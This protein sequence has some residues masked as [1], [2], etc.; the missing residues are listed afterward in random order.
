LINLS[1][2]EILEQLSHYRAKQKQGALIANPTLSRMNSRK[3]GKSSD[4]SAAF[5]NVIEVCDVKLD[6]NAYILLYCF[7]QC[8]VGKTELKAE[9]LIS[10]RSGTHCHGSQASSVGRFRYLFIFIAPRYA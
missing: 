5:S 4:F 7:L 10:K 3:T 9:G 6:V 8:S 1:I 2:S